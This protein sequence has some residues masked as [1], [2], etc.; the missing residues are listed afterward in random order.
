MS[1]NNS[2]PT[3]LGVVAIAVTLWLATVNTELQA[4]LKTC[5]S[6]FQGFKEGVIYGTK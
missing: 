5:Q 3:I 1:E 2:A 6:E 4:K